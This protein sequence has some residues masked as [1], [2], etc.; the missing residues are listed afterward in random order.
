MGNGF[1]IHVTAVLYLIGIRDK[2]K[3][4]ML[5]LSA[6]FAAVPILCCILLQ[7]KS[8]SSS[9]GL[10]QINRSS[11]P[12]CSNKKLPNRPENCPNLATASFVLKV[13]FFKIALKFSKYFGNFC[14]KISS[15]GLS[16]IA[17]SGHTEQKPRRSEC[18]QMVFTT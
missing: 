5:H 9:Y 13:P 12:R 11:V 3:I 17:K 4:F 6:S 15:Q 1:T 10:K 16:K 2:R 8:E 14:N 18:I 7:Q